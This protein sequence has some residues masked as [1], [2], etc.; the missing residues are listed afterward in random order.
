M[1]IN[2]HEFDKKVERTV[3]SIISSVVKEWD[4]SEFPE[5]EKEFAK[6][7]ITTN[8]RFF[9]VPVLKFMNMKYTIK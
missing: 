6:G 5:K 2:K 1:E 8:D 3:K 4:A 7:I 9:K